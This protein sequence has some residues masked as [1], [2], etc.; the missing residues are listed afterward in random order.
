MSGSFTEEDN[1][2]RLAGV[3]RQKNGLSTTYKPSQMAQAILDLNTE[4]TGEVDPVSIEILENTITSL[5]D[6]VNRKIRSIGTYALYGCNNLTSI[7]LPLTTSIGA[8]A[9]YGCT[10][11]STLHIPAVTSVGDYAFYGCTGIT[12]LGDGIRIGSVA[13]NAFNGCTNLTEYKSTSGGTL[14]T[15]SFKDCSSLVSVDVGGYCNFY[16]CFRGCTSLESITI[17]FTGYVCVWQSPT[18]IRTQLADTKI[19]TTGH[20]YVPENLIDIY[21]TADGWSLIQD[22]IEVIPSSVVEGGE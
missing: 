11:L 8:Y 4:S 6:S 16:D 19:L 20:V 21:K 3:I 10:A 9:F 7:N 14:N 15:N 18:S 2:V 13:S 5:D 17:R 1:I 22:R 12:S